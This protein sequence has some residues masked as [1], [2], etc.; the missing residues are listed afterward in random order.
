MWGIGNYS[1]GGL[2]MNS[3]VDFVIAS[4]SPSTTASYAS[5]EV[6]PTVGLRKIRAK[7]IQ[8]AYHHLHGQEV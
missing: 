8:K 6:L 5:S 4:F 3:L 2:V 1:G 7:R